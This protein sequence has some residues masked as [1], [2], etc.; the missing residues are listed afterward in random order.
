MFIILVIIDRRSGLSRGKTHE[1]MV[2]L[3]VRSGR[4]FGKVALAVNGAPSGIVSLTENP[5][6]FR[7]LP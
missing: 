6:W 4:A 3:V 7:V 1:V 5:V 2:P